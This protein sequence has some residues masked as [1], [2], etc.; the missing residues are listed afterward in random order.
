MRWWQSLANDPSKFKFRR[1]DPDELAHYSKDC[2]DIEYEYP[3]GWDELEGIAHRGQYDL[4]AHSKGMVSEKQAASP[5]FKPKLVYFDPER[6][7]PT[8]ARRGIATCPR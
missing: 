3:W 6:E 2:Y 4:T 1:H 7:D 8:R 5:K